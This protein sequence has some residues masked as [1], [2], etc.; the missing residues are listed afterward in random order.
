MTLKYAEEFNQINPVDHRQNDALN[1][2]HQNEKS[3]RIEDAGERDQKR[4]E[5]TKKQC[6]VHFD[7]N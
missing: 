3:E 5:W 1:E 4:V 7:F 6:F 2:S